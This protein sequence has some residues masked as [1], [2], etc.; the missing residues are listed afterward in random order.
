MVVSSQKMAIGDPPPM[1]TYAR[2][3][4]LS[5]RLAS[6]LTVSGLLHD[7]AQDNGA[8]ALAV[9]CQREKSMLSALA[10]VQ[11]CTRKEGGRDERHSACS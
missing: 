6:K 2:A 8:V 10:P 4:T 1:Q 7:A 3:D 11:A 9:L 5:S